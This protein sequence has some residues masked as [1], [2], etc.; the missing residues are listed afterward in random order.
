[1]SLESWDTVQKLQI[2]LFGLAGETGALN[3]CFCSLVS[4]L[5]RTFADDTFLFMNYWTDGV[6]KW[7]IFTEPTLNNFHLNR[8]LLSRPPVWVGRMLICRGCV[9]GVSVGEAQEVVLVQVHDDQLV[10]W[11]QVH[12]HLGEFLVKVT[13]VSTAP[14]QVWRVMAE[15]RTG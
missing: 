7:Q 5:W 14:L 4:S 8:L 10:R 11:S 3:I 13:S 2:P 9:L 12:W 15:R 1:M 6:E